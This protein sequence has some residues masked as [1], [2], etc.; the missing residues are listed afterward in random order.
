MRSDAINSCSFNSPRFF[1]VT[2][3]IGSLSTRPAQVLL[4]SKRTITAWR[5]AF[6]RPT[7]PNLTHAE[8][9][10]SGKI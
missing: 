8:R 10:P 7:E 1:R 4:L 9:L 2:N 3:E 5:L 6:D